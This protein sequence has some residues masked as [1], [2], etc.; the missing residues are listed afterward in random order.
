MFTAR[1]RP[2]A[3]RWI[4]AVTTG[5]SAALSIRIYA[6][7]DQDVAGFQF[8]EKIPLVPPLGISYEVGAD[9]ISLL[10]VLL[11]SIIIVA[12]MLHSEGADASSPTMSFLTRAL[13]SAPYTVV[14]N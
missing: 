3:V 2:R 14:P 6:T 7:Y 13:D 5:I 1:H 9:G 10:M 8:Y 4:A 11:T 12:G